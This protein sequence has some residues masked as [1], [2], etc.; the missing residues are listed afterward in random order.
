MSLIIFNIGG[1][2]YNEIASIE[3]LE[4]FKKINNKIYLGTTCIMNSYEY[5]NQLRNIN[6]DYEKK[7]KNDYNEDYNLKK[8]EDEDAYILD[9]NTN[10]KNNLNEDLPSEKE[11]L[12]GDNDLIFI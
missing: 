11:K 3:N 7:I 6:K 1:L 12:L 10:N 9:V 8:E 4:N 2:S 5:M